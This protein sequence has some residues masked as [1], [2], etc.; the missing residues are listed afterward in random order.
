MLVKYIL[1][2]MFSFQL[3]INVKI[4]LASID[5]FLGVVAVTSTYKENYK[6]M[7]R[8]CGSIQRW[9]LISAFVA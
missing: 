8:R 4:I 1:K 5:T 6:A 3:L 7:D 9:R 2:L